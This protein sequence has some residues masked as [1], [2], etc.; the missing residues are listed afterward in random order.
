MGGAI[1]DCSPII[2]REGT[3]REGRHYLS[4]R[5][6]AGDSPL[7]LRR[8]VL[9]RRDTLEILAVRDSGQDGMVEFSG[10]AEQPER[11]LVMIVLDNAGGDYNG[12]VAD[13]LTQEQEP[14][15]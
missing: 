7:F 13:F 9:M 15:T 1:I 11:S 4:G 2:V 10:L 5:V 14:I 8:V 3:P 12:Y 6:T